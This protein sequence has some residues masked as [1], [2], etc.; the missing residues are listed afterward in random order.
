MRKHPLQLE[1]GGIMKE[2][3]KKA[4][5]V[6]AKNTREEPT[7]ERKEQAHLLMIEDFYEGFKE[8]SDFI[9]VL[10]TSDN[11]DFKK[12]RRILTG[13][14]RFYLDEIKSD[15][16]HA[17]NYLYREY[18]KI[19]ENNKGVDITVF[20]LIF[21]L[22]SYSNNLETKINYYSHNDMELAPLEKNNEVVKELKEISLFLKLVRNIPHLFSEMEEEYID[23]II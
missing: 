2:Q 20:S 22:F 7:M 17:T 9:K 23:R 4:R 3:K 6:S 13:D 11:E 12:F 18:K 16:I 8:M 14:G 19:A 1:K 15:L 5:V 10:Q 21:K